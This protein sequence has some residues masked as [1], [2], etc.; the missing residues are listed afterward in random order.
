VHTKGSIQICKA[1]KVAM[2]YFCEQLS[3]FLDLNSPI[4]GTK[5]NDTSPVISPILLKPIE[6]LELTVRSSNCLKMQNIR[7]LGDLVQYQESELMYIPNLG[8]KSLNEL[9]SV[10]S[11]YGLSFGIK[12]ENWPLTL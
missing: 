2:T 6:D 7:L 12:I 4:V 1:I 9:K 11:D 5:N 8:R 10:L 3:V